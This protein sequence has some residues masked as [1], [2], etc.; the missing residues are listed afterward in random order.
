MNLLH[1]RRDRTHDLWLDLEEGAGQLHLLVT[2]SGLANPEEEEE[3]QAG[4]EERIKNN[5][6][7]SKSLSNFNEIGHLVVKVFCARGLMAADLGGKSDPYAV[8]EL[9]NERLQT[10]TQYKTVNPVWNRTFNFIV[11]DVNSAL[12]IT[13]N[14][15]DSKHT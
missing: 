13:V 8:L 15:E 4:L 2:V 7:W 1:L 14:D 10:H 11:K 3:Q 9:D 12:T 6:Q 5:F